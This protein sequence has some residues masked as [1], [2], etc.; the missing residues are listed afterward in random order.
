MNQYYY[1]PSTTG[2][3]LG[4]LHREMPGDVIEVSP[5]DY[6]FLIEGQSLGKSIVYRSRKL[7]LVEYVPLALTWDSIRARRDVY[8]TKSDWTQ[9]PD[10]QMDSK[11][12]EAW[13]VYRQALRDITETFAHPDEVVWPKTP[14]SEDSTPTKE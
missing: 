14:D 2:F 13:R 6:R 4:G 1:S 10:N 11:L 5:E 9:I 8:L 3:Y 12:V 7:Q